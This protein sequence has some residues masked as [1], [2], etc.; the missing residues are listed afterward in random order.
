MG[1]LEPGDEREGLMAGPPAP[2]ARKRFVLRWVTVLGVAL[3]AVAVW[4]AISTIGTEQEVARADD[5]PARLQPSQAQRRAA[6]RALTPTEPGA[7]TVEESGRSGVYYRNCD[8][9]RA[10]GAAPLRMGQPGYRRGL[11]RDG[12]GVACE[13]PRE[14]RPPR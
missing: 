11:D 4:F 10:A 7:P 1:V 8:A 14:P 12:D 6:V 3:A 13:P 2:P 5:P 9:V